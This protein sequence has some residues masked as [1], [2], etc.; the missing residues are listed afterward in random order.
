MESTIHIHLQNSQENPLHGAALFGKEE[1]I[2]CNTFQWSPCHVFHWSPCHE[3]WPRGTACYMLATGFLY[4]L[5][6]R[7]FYLLSILPPLLGL[8]GHV[9]VHTVK[10]KVDHQ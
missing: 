6:L 7:L 9:H 1:L 4:S 5:K 10:F 2:T 3:L 8:L